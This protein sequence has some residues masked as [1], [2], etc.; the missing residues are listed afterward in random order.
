METGSC[1]HAVTTYS[2]GRLEEKRR[3]PAPISS[4]AL[5]AKVRFLQPV[6][7]DRSVGRSINAAVCI[8]A[9]VHPCCFQICL[10]CSIRVHT[11]WERT[12]M[13]EVS[14]TMCVCCL[15][16]CT[17]SNLESDSEAKAIRGL[18]SS[19]QYVK[20]QWLWHCWGLRVQL[21]LVST[22]SCALMKS[23]EKLCLFR[24]QQSHIAFWNWILAV[25]NYSLARWK[26]DFHLPLFTCDKRNQNNGSL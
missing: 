8:C 10:K 3:Q 19:Q 12:I 24:E 5:R 13:V 6:C 17:S 1:L 7:E 14:A 4:H 20:L 11:Q 22:S 9:T 18:V 2:R 23:C 21:H 25:L 15:H 16:I 26:I